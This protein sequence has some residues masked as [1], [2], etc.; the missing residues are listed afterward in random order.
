[1]YLFSSACFVVVVGLSCGDSHGVPGRMRLPICC[2][3]VWN[4]IGDSCWL[5]SKEEPHGLYKCTSQL[6]MQDVELL[7]ALV[8]ENC[9]YNTSV[10][11][12]KLYLSDNILLVVYLAPIVSR[13]ELFVACEEVGLQDFKPHNALLD[14]LDSLWI[15]WS[16]TENSA[17]LPFQV[18][19]R[20]E[21]G[22]G[23]M[24]GLETEVPHV[25]SSIGS[26]SKP[27]E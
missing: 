1:M 27:F 3:D 12:A 11:A 10:V 16:H 9:A 2:G 25:E 23:E 7:A 15:G 21:M 6:C 22:L 13:D 4:V 8:H 14:R 26:M 24:P 18:W 20:G 19:F 17:A 5:F